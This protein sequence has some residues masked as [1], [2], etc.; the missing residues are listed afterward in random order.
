MATAEHRLS[1]LN[2]LETLFNLIQ[3]SI[4]DPHQLIIE[5]HWPQSLRIPSYSGWLLAYGVIYTF[6]GTSD[7]CMSVENCLANCPLTVY[8][9]IAT[10]SNQLKQ[11]IGL[12][13]AEQM[14]MSF[15]IPVHLEIQYP[16]RDLGRETEEKFA[17]AP[18]TRRLF[19]HCRVVKD[20]VS[21]P[22]VVL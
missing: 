17:K 8:K 19:E 21:L 1:L 16:D 3:S 18:Q 14:I 11:E 22:T 7:D 6:G 5:T 15:S 4:L 12:T 2:K 9:V 20:L 13:E 10:V